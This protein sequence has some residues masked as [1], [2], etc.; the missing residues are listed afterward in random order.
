MKRGQ[1]DLKKKSLD[2][3]I[4]L[5]V[6]MISLMA[7]LVWITVR[8][9]KL[10]QKR[11]GYVEEIVEVVEVKES[12]LHVGA[13]SRTLVISPTSFRTTIYNESKGKN[14]VRYEV[15][16][17]GE[18]REIELYLTKETLKELSK[19]Y[20]DKAGKTLKIAKGVK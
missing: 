19:E 9:Y 10:E 6:P 13:E 18:Y 17:D 14:T 7:I 5:I 4:Y 1:V 20:A 16:D 2:I 15:R 8:D 11:W 3:L 12:R